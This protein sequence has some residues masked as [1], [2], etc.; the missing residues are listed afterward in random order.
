ML[1]ME[2]PVK[3][4]WEGLKGGIWVRE[5][6]ALVD[7]MEEYAEDRNNWKWKTRCGDP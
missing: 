1:R 5:D 6:M 7:V 3:G 2:L 4:K